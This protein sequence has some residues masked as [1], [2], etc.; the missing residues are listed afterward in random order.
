MMRKFIYLLGFIVS[1]AEGAERLASLVKIDG[2]IGPVTY[3][4]IRR[5]IQ[6]ATKERAEFLLIYLDT[7]GG[8]L[9]STRKIVQEILEA[10]VPVVGYVAPK[11]A[12][13]ASA[14]TFIG[15]ACHILAMAPATNIGAAHPVS[16]FSKEDKTMETKAVNDTVAFIKSIASLR[17]RNASWAEKAVRESLSSTEKEALKQRVCDLVAKDID[18]LLLQLNGRSIHLRGKERTINTDRIAIQ[19]SS[20]RLVERILGLL[21]EPN[22]AYL[23]LIIGFWGIIIEL[24]HPG[25]SLPGVVGIIALILGFF[26]LQAIS[27]NTAGVILIF[28][29]LI[30]FITETFTPG[31]G[32]FLVAGIV[33]LLLGSLMLTRPEPGGA[34]SRTLIVGSAAF[35]GV[36]LG[37][38]LW[39]VKSARRRQVTTGQEGLIGEK[40]RVVST[41]NPE[42]MVFVHGEYWKARSF[43]GPIQEKQCIRV[44]S[45]EGM[46]LT[47]EPVDQEEKNE[48]QAEENTSS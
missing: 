14:G 36:L 18:D 45:V 40:G 1:V 11:G 3:H 34:I 47:V 48:K 5:A 44:V 37:N 28:L 21:S 43:K 38:I 19:E 33:S 23:L 22:I 17:G 46:T 24:S 16:L 7:P 13:C 25:A 30:F 27:L 9:S 31:F 35:T 42:G 12:Q 20:V 39:L 15:L 26:A 41:L 32:T 6:S 8:L 4:Q 10:D 29:S 2:P